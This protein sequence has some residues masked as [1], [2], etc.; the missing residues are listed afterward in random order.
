MQLPIYQANVIKA[1]F[2]ANG[3]KKWLTTK[4]VSG[5]IDSSWLICHEK[6]MK[7]ASPRIIKPEIKPEI[8]TSEKVMLNQNCLSTFGTSMKKF[9]NSNSMAV[10]PHVM[11]ISNMWAR[12]ASETPA[13][14]C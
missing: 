6:G 12:R 13:G 8:N 14:L 10:A 5:T 9:E 11:L 1:G 3:N 7:D 2:N 4:L